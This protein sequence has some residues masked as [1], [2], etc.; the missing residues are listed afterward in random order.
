M[1]YQKKR[2]QI[3]KGEYCYCLPT[4]SLK[5]CPDCQFKLKHPAI[6]FSELENEPQIPINDWDKVDAHIE[7]EDILER[8]NLPDRQLNALIKYLETGDKIRPAY[9]D[10]IKTIRKEFH[11]TP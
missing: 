2:C 9:Y 4:D 6:N 1:E 5:F 8:V 10:A 3:C 11:K 7:V